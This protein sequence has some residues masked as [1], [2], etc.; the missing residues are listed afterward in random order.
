[1]TLFWPKKAYINDTFL[2]KK[3][4]FLI[5]SP[6]PYPVTT[7]WNR[8]EKTIPMSGHSIGFGEEIRTLVYQ[9]RTLSG[10]LLTSKYSSSLGAHFKRKLAF[11]F[12][13]DNLPICFKLSRPLYMMKWNQCGKWANAN[14]FHNI[15]KAIQYFCSSRHNKICIH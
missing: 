11:S 1:M 2:T 6:K 10:V 12:F 15:F 5:S 8:L 7:H 9:K 14:F 3:I 13:L 4:F